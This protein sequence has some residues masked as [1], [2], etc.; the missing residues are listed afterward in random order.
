MI[1]ITHIVTREL[2][3]PGTAVARQ[4]TINTHIL[5]GRVG[6]V[7]TAGTYHTHTDYSLQECIIFYQKL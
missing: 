2:L 6:N 5:D 1:S 4:L 3:T 7:L